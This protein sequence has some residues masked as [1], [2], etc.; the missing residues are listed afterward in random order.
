MQ[1]VETTNEGLKRGY[2]VTIPAALIASK[3]E[4]EIARVAPQVQ[5]PGFRP[6]KVP[7]N[8]VRKRFGARSTRT[9]SGS[10]REALDKVV[11]EQALRP[12]TQPEVSLGEGYA[13]GQDATLTVA[14]EVLP[15]IS[16]PDLSGLKL[17]KLVVPV[18][19]EALDEAVQ[20]VAS[21]A[22]R[23]NDAE[24]GKLA[25]TGD[26][27][28]IDFLGKLDGVPFDGG[29]AEDAALEIGS[30]RFIPGFEEQLVGA[31]VGDERSSP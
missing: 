6:G 20:R 4:G 15:V 28:I 18:A 26:Q 29:Q 12:A 1:I 27:L 14:L 7:A 31:K 21:S 19:E 10:I 2:T 5:L 3:V 22:K 9:L 8:I 11:V 13:E 24:E 25:E 17:E 16:A 30:G 23:F